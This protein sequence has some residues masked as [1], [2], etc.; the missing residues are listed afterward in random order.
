MNRTRLLILLVVLIGVLLI[1]TA[2]VAAQNGG[3]YDLTWN[4]IDNGGGSSSGG[5]YTV[6][7]TLGQPDAVAQ[8]T[9]SPYTLV[10][11]FW[12]SLLT[13]YKVYLPVSLR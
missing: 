11:G 10:G 1:M 2:Q 3:S 6:E 8:M 5:S 12:N 4:T 13:P 9:N 7:G